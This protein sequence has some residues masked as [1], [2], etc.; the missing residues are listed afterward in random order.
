MWLWL[1]MYSSSTVDLPLCP[2]QPIISFFH[3]SKWNCWILC[4]AH[5]AATF[6]EEKTYR[7]TFVPCLDTLWNEQNTKNL[8]F[9]EIKMQRT[10]RVLLLLKF[11]RTCSKC[12]I[13]QT[14]QI[15]S[16]VPV[17]WFVSLCVDCVFFSLFIKKNRRKVETEECK[18]HGMVSD[19]TL[20][21]FNLAQKVLNTLRTHHYECEHGRYPSRL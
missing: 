14:H 1:C 2:L 7:T 17:S 18:R 12:T 19:S 8:F 3:I 13:H 21:P 16:D 10:L 6:H 15:H 11:F 4:D 20:S 9:F 5:Y